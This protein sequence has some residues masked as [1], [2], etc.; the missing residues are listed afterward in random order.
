M[1]IKSDTLKEPSIISRT[2]A[3]VWSETNF[4]PTGHHRPR[5]SPLPLVCTIPSASA[6]SKC[7]LEVVFCECVQHRLRFCLDHFNCV[8]MAAGKQRKVRWVAD[9]SH[10][11]FGQKLPR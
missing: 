3:A 9:D 11:A 10:V 5:S 7:T 1:Q 6:I 8:K 2:V 4:G